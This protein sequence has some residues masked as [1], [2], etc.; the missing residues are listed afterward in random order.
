MQFRKTHFLIWSEDPDKL[1]K[2]YKDVLELDFKE[3]VDIEATKES[4]SD[5]GYEFQLTPDVGLWIGKHSEVNGKSKDPLRIMHNLY[6]ESVADWT[7]KVRNGGAKVISEPMKTPF[8]SST[9]PWWVSTFRDPDGNV[10]QFM[11]PK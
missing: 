8:F 9:L 6:V 2:F 11:G 5:Y 3:K 1:M 7:N 4:V 10:W